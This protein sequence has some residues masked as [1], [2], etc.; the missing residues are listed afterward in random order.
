MFRWTCSS[1]SWAIWDLV[2][3]KERKKKRDIRKVVREEE[4][5]RPLFSLGS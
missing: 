4:I 2:K 1:S 5:E 3:K